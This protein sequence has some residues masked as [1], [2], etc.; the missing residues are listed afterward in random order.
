MKTYRKI[1]LTS[2]LDV[3]GYKRSAS[4]LFRFN[5]Q[6]KSPQYP[7]N[8]T[9]GR[10]QSRSGSHEEEKISFPLLRIEPQS[11]S[12]YSVVTP[13]ELPQTLL[14]SWACLQAYIWTD[15]A[16]LARSAC[17]VYF[18]LWR[19]K[20]Y[21]CEH[22]PNYNVWAVQLCAAAETGSVVRALKCHLAE[23]FPLPDLLWEFRVPLL[24]KGVPFASV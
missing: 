16:L 4:R 6:G 19:W 7:L 23:Q 20:Q 1:F 10:K 8:R 22:I 2:T 5:S 21:V 12:P 14:D 15:S 3:N 18:R 24:A 13:T 9:L 11:S 17:L